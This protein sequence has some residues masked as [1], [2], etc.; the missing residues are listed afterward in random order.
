[1]LESTTLS[2]TNPAI[3]WLKTNE[4]FLVVDGIPRHK[5][6]YTESQAQ[7]SDAFGYKWHKV[8]TFE[9]D[10]V[11]ETARAWLKDRYA[12]P[13]HPLEELTRGKKILDAGCGAGHSALLLFGEL[14]NQA[15]YV[16][17]D[18]STAIDVAK[19]RFE[20][21]GVQGAFVQCSLM[22]LPEEL[23]TFD[24]IFSE[25]VLH[26]TDSTEQAVRYMASKLNPGG[27]FMFYVYK[28]KGP[29]REFTDDYIRE[30]IAPM[31][32]EEA[33]K[34]LEPLTKLGKTLGDLDIEIDVEEPIDILEIP[35]GKI[36][37]QRLFYWHIFKAFYRPEWSL[38]EMNNCN[39]DWYRPTNS[40]RQTPDEVRAW[41]E[42]CGLR[43]EQFKVE[44]A[45]IT[46]IAHRPAP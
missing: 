1:M 37:L 33:W 18:I 13:G 24:I 15:Q 32:D 7:T 12:F 3:E 20:K 42:S 25:G 10:H 17:A 28:K 9:A 22:E 39:F 5:K 29:I 2:S 34:A 19:Q 14:L 23:G 6:F 21:R 31:S 38:G 41:V 35:A 8:E 36:N 11:Q 44:E 40:Y 46:V 43:I 4:Q 16:G 45:G 26:H 30:K 27:Y